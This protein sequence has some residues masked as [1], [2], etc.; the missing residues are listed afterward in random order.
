ML[1]AIRISLVIPTYNR[2]SLI[3]ETIDSALR[4]EHPFAEIIVVDD[5]S[6]DH[7]GDV[8]ARYGD[9][10]KV[11]RIPNGGVQRARNVGVA[12]TSSPWVMFCDSDDLMLPELTTRLAQ[13]LENDTH[14]DAIYCNFVTFTEEQ[15]EK[16]DKFSQAPADFFAGAKRSGDIW[17]D[18][19]DLYARSV[20]YQ[21]LFF[22]GNIVRKAVY[23]TLG[24]FDTQF[25]GIG[26]EDWEFTLR[27]IGARRIALCALP[28]VRIRRHAGNDSANN[29]RQNSGCISILE[30]ALQHHPAAERYREQILHNIDLRRLDVFNGAFADGDFSLAARTLDELRKR[31]HDLKFRIKALITRLPAIAR[32]PLWRVTQAG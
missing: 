32:M 18:I 4:Q 24:G 25:N 13:W 22:S 11:I 19:P 2:G 1:Q 7:T 6:T 15:S 9:H 8:L 16:A 17:H 23:E 30:H 10:I 31:P 27:L 12:A 28:L 5:G 3:A 26:G 29:L 14:C 21:P 20:T